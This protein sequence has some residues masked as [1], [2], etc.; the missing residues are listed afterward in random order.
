MGVGGRGEQNQTHAAIRIKHIHSANAV[1]D[2][3]INASLDR[4]KVIKF[5]ELIN[6]LARRYFTGIALRYS[7][8]K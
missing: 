8:I 7:G 4:K 3:K 1:N 2:F 5:A 6:P